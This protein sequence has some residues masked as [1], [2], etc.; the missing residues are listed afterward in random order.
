[1]L[2]TILIFIFKLIM[3]FITLFIWFRFL[4]PPMLSYPDNIIFF[5]GV[6]ST[7]IFSLSWFYFLLLT[8]NKFLNKF[9]N[10]N[11]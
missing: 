4:I 3:Y 2:K 9:T 11:N 7:I 5:V 10:E 1:M 8:I 6:F